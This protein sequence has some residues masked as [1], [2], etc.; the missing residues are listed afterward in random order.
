MDK[1]DAR[2]L[3]MGIGEGGAIVLRIHANSSRKALVEKTIAITP[4]A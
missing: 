4:H 3:V 1:A 2:L